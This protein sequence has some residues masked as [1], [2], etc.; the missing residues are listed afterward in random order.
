MPGYLPFYSFAMPQMMMYPPQTGSRVYV[1]PKFAQSSQFASQELSAPPAGLSPE[2]LRLREQIAA[3]RRRKEAA[4][5]NAQG[6]GINI[7]KVLYYCIMIMSAVANLTILFQAS[8]SQTSSQVS[9]NGR[10]RNSGDDAIEVR[11]NK[12]PNTS[13]APTNSATSHTP[14]QGIKIKG[15][16][17]ANREN[18]TNNTSMQTSSSGI[19]KQVNNDPAPT[20][21]RITIKGRNA[22]NREQSAN[23]SILD[24]LSLSSPLSSSSPSN[25]R[26]HD[27]SS[28][29]KSTE[30]TI[31][32]RGSNKEH[33]MNASIL[34]RLSSSSPSNSSSS[35]VPN[36]NDDSPVAG[37]KGMTIKGCA[38]ANREHSILNRI[39][40]SPQANASS[41]NNRNRRNNGPATGSL[42]ITITGSAN[43]KKNANNTSVFSRLSTSQHS[44]TSSPSVFDR[45]NSPAAGSSSTQRNTAEARRNPVYNFL[46]SGRGVKRSQEFEETNAS[47]KRTNI[48]SIQYRRQ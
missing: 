19:H 45:L 41:P 18:T 35:R 38:S 26:Y 46:M 47:H 8:D 33:S 42:G 24:R 25:Q 48:R 16:A 32:G 34:D 44:N 21:S 6:D 20:S 40:A 22:A 17:T 5:A 28:A 9:T 10:K 14:Y 29:T 2:L 43:I 15:A 36:R 27:N 37:N 7:S 1:N 13:S 3:T 31:R 11:S 39:S 4:K 23:I 12:R 30:V